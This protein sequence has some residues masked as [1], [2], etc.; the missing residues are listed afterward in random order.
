VAEADGITFTISISLPHGAVV[1]KVV[2]YGNAAASAET[3]GLWR[4]D[5]DTINS[6]KLDRGKY[7]H[8]GHFN[9]IRNH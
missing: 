6:E 9:F 7:K 5:I 4:D 8:R 3:W 1:T 2:V